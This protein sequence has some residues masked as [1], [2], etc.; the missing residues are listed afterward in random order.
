MGLLSCR[1]DT[2]PFRAASISCW[3]TPSKGTSSSTC[4]VPSVMVPVLS[5]HRVST[6]ANVSTQYKSRTRV[7]RAESFT[8]LTAKHTLTSSTRP[9]GIMPT[10]AAVVLTTEFCRVSPSTKNCFQN[11]KAPMGRMPKPT[12]LTMRSMESIISELR[13]FMYLA[14]P[15]ILVA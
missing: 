2:R 6:R 12:T 8:T 11:S 3:V 10:M 1:L 14:S 15:V 13:C 7:F 5:R 4:M 9:S